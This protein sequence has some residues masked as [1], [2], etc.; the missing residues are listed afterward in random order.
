[1]SLGNL[2]S[3]LFGSGA[4]KSK[5]NLEEFVLEHNSDK[6]L[7]AGSFNRLVQAVG[8]AAPKYTGFDPEKYQAGLEK[9]CSEYNPFVK[10][11]GDNAYRIM[12]TEPEFSRM[13]DTVKCR[14]PI[15]VLR[16]QPDCQH[17]VEGSLRYLFFVETV[18]KALYGMSEE[19]QRNTVQTAAKFADTYNPV[20]GGFTQHISDYVYRETEKN[21]KHFIYDH[22]KHGLN[23]LKVLAGDRFTDYVTP[24][25]ALVEQN[26]E[27]SRDLPDLIFMKNLKALTE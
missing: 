5:P 9:F 1:M 27:Q 13:T 22:A 21:I 26:C 6:T 14:V 18:T 2:L 8:V 10:D 16:F 7:F 17:T 19:G 12:T 24:L 20:E 4:K 25:I 3:R 15:T 11:M 23:L